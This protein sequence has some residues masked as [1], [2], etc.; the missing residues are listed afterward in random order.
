MIWYS[1]ANGFYELAFDIPFLFLQDMMIQ[2]ENIPRH[3]IGT[4]ITILGLFFV[5]GKFLTGVIEQFL[6]I[7]P[8]I[9]SFASML[10]LA[11]VI[12]FIPL[13]LIEFF[14][15]ENLSEAY[16]LLMFVKVFFVL[17]GPPIVGAIID[18]TGI[19]KAAFYTSGSFQLLG[20]LLNSL[21]FL[22]QIIP[23]DD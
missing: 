4:V 23:D 15:G 9:L 14:G 5:I 3:K 12:V 2:D 21:V 22:F 20:G 16:G 18:Y 7:S 13:I 1:L 17:W 10:M 19:Y 11:S 8:I 6:K